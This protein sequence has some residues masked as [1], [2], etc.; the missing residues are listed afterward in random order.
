MFKIIINKL[1]RAKENISKT[2]MLE[3]LKTNENVIL[4]DVRSVQEY[5][6]GNLPRKYKY[7]IIWNTKKSKFRIEK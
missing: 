6:E 3:I 2:E 1:N 4:L 5:K 7:T